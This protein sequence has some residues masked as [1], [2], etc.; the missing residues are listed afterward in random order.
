MNGIEVRVDRSTAREQL[1]LKVFKKTTPQHLI[2]QK[3]GFEPVPKTR[4]GSDIE[5]RHNAERSK[6]YSTAHLPA[7]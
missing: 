1:H 7:S 2:R 6:A 4:K 5:E 3:V